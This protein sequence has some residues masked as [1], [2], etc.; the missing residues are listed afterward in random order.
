M[1]RSSL[2]K[3]M[4]GQN[5]R[6]DKFFTSV[7]HILTVQNIFTKKKKQLKTTKMYSHKPS[8]SFHT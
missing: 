5:S 4:E 3:K 2:K 7:L 6:K 8:F 1:V